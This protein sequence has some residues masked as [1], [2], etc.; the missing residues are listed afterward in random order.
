[1]TDLAHFMEFLPCIKAETDVIVNVSTDDSLSTGIIKRMAPAVAAS[2]EMC[3]LNTGSLNF[4][5][6]PLT[7][8][9]AECKCDWEQDYI[10]RSISNV[11]RNTF[12]DIENVAK[13]LVWNNDC[14]SEN[15]FHDVRQIQNHVFMKQTADCL[16]GKDYQRSMIG[17]GAAQMRLGAVAAQMSGHVRAD[18]EASLLIERGKLATSDVQEV[19]KMREILEDQGNTI[20]TPQAVRALISPKGVDQV[21]F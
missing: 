4:A 13:T 1:M 16:F 20:A 2:P 17:A 8:H 5:M 14:K 10:C 7:N 15:E 21:T 19:T 9:Y 18:L 3:L 6:H 12:D 11:F